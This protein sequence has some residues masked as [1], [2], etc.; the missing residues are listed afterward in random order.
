MLLEIYIGNEKNKPKKSSFKHY[1]CIYIANKIIT[2][3]F[4]LSLLV[5]SMENVQRI[6]FNKNQLV[7]VNKNVDKHNIEAWIE[8]IYKQNIA[9]VV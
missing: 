2:M 5:L 9:I 8:I 6:K 4:F 1:D 3:V 7:C